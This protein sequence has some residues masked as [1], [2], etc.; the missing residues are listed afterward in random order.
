MGWRGWSGAGLDYVLESAAVRCG[1][2]QWAFSVVDL[3]LDILSIA[4]K[5][6]NMQHATWGIQHATYIQLG[7][8]FF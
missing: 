8:C 3:E 7:E 2:V 4:I 5:I 6:I 1:Q